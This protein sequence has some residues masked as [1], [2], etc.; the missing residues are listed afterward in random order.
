MS[1]QEIRAWRNLA[2]RLVV[3]EERTKLLSSLLSRGVGL[4]EE[5]DFFRHEK[6]KFKGGGPH[7][8]C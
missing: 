1:A 7:G 4:K 5:E 8:C 6:S 2:K 3:T